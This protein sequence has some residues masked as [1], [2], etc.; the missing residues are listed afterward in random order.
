MKLVSLRMIGLSCIYFLF[1][2]FSASAGA[3][4]V[5]QAGEGVSVEGW[6]AVGSRELPILGFDDAFFPDD[7]YQD[8][9]AENVTVDK[10]G[11]M[12]FQLTHNGPLSRQVFAHVRRVEQDDGLTRSIITNIADGSQMEYLSRT[13]D[14]PVAGNRGKT[15][16][17][18]MSTEKMVGQDQDAECPWCV[19]FGF[20]ISEATCAAATSM[21]HYQCRADCEMLGGVRSFDSGVCGMYNSECKCM[22]DPKRINEEF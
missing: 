14:V 19:W 1:I 2:A 21:A 3:T 12:R 9:R 8:I 5:E 6:S 7:L 16:D 18:D 11:S 10:D 4:G 22:V 17:F 20:F 13:V 15:G